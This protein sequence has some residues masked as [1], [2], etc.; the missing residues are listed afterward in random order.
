MIENTGSFKISVFSGAFAPWIWKKSDRD[1]R[2]PSSRISS[3][4]RVRG[5]VPWVPEAVSLVSEAGN[6][7]R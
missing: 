2:L 1:T 5:L 3:M 4:V 6:R 7:I